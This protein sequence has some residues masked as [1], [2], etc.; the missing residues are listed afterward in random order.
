MLYIQNQVA[1]FI[2]YI[3]KKSIIKN[4]VNNDPYNKPQPNDFI[5]FLSVILVSV[6]TKPGNRAP[7]KKSIKGYGASTNLNP[8]M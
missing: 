5:I 1:K 7:K 6:I 4:T 8:K 2:G 3:I